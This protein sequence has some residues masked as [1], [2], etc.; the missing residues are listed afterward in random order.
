[1]NPTLA[2]QLADYAASLTYDD[3]DA[4]T[5]EAIKRQFADAVGCA[6][7][8]VEEPPI[9]IARKVALACGKGEATL[10]GTRSKTSP[11]MAAFVNGAAVRHYDYNDIYAAKEIGHPSDNIPACLA[12]AETQGASGR[13]LILAIAIAYE[14][15]CRLIDA[16]SISSRG[17]DHPCY[18]LPAVALAAGKLMKL[19]REQMV[20]AVN[21][22]VGGH[23][24]LN[25]TRVQALSNWKGL[26]DGNAARNAVFAATLA[27][28][29]LTGP[30]PIFEGNAG[31]FKHVSGPFTV[32]TSHFGGAG[33]PFRIHDCTV[34]FY[35]ALGMA[36]TAVPAAI[37]VAR[38][39]GGVDR[40]AQVQ[41][42]TSHA[43][44]ITAGRDPQKWTPQN[45]E[46]AD[47]SLPYIVSKAM[48]DGDIDHHSYSDAA[49]RD[50][51]LRAFMQKVTVSED[52]QL[53]ALYPAYYPTRVTVT[54]D[55]GQVFSKQ[56]N[57]TPGFP[58][59]P[60]Q[61]PDFERKFRKNTKG[62]LD[63]ERTSRLLDL[64]WNLDSLQDFSQLWP[65]MAV[66]D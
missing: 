55:D 24:A 34:K 64:I 44:Y 29:G 18:S 14:V 45:S 46:T 17:W 32:D 58:T 39:A 50:P 15:V 42:H 16:A 61:R 26:A 62:I 52:P 63:P 41:I 11:D 30:S 59:S 54:L 6:I 28:E 48:F 12:V 4:G 60:M 53:T 10:F 9:R 27:A 38:Q 21:I 57:D 25:Q 43:G 40:I 20:E 22:A 35:P 19:T 1:M 51:V 49:L 66:T 2:E 47:H 56:M 7:S 33:R 8:A 23:L 5:V 37:D 36:Q 31:F 13:D 65:A 3:L